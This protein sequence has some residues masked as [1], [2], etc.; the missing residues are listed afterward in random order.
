MTID[1]KFL[2][3]EIESL[4][5]LIDYSGSRFVRETQNEALLDHHNLIIELITYQR[6]IKLIR[7]LN[8]REFQL[9]KKKG[10]L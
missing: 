1:L 7:G 6:L 5:K 9:E 2:R 3:K 8:E 4:N 10:T